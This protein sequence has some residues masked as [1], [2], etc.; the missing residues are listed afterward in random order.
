MPKLFYA[1]HTFEL[2]EKTEALELAAAFRAMS[3]DTASHVFNISTP[4]G[5]LSLSFGPGIP[6]AIL[7]TAAAG[8]ALTDDDLDKLAYGD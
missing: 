4:D 7:D 5:V 6:W 1:G 3:N 2:P 8:S